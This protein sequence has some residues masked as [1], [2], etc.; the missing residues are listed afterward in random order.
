MHVIR[1]KKYGNSCLK[2]S[3]QYFQGAPDIG[4]IT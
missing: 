3:K 2:M 4:K 1:E